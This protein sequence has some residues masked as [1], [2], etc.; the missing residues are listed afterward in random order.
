MYRLVTKRREAKCRELFTAM[1][2]PTLKLHHL[3]PKEQNETNV[4]H[5]RKCEPFKTKTERFRK[6][7]ITH[8]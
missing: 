3:L 7:P 5:F 2:R 4:R 1:E 6:S 8:K